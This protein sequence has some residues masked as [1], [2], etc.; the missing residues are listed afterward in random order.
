M[1]VNTNDIFDDARFM[2]YC[3]ELGKI[4]SYAERAAESAVAK[5]TYILQNPMPSLRIINMLYKD[6]HSCLEEAIIVAK[7]L[8][9]KRERVIEEFMKHYNRKM[10]H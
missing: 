3:N 4:D 2:E 7:T 9:I 6:T 1:E 8:G 5:N 10:R